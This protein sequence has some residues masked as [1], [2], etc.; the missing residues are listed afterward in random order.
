MVKF[1]T[2]QQ[3]NVIAVNDTLKCQSSKYVLHFMTI[4]DSIYLASGA[5][6]SHFANRETVVL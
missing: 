5:F 1:G 6:Q 4:Y 3:A 2:R